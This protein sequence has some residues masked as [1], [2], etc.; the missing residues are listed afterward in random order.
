MQLR[1]KNEIKR[2]P[3]SVFIRQQLSKSF[4]KF[5][6]IYHSTPSQFQR[7]DEGN[8]HFRIQLHSLGNSLQYGKV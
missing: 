4:R 3:V 5:R 6:E 2:I 8:Y 7:S 1:F